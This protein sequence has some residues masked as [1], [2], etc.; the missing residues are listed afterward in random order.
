MDKYC[1]VIPEN[2]TIWYFTTFMVLLKFQAFFPHLEFSPRPTA[3][4]NG[5][6]P[7]C[8]SQLFAQRLK[9]KKEE[10]QIFHFFAKKLNLNEIGVQV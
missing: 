9:E 6:Q 10:R 5:A 7:F 1:Y 4:R 8:G 3:E 2:E